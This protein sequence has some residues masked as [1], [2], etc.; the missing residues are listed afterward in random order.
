MK[1][2]V[3]SKKLKKRER[4]SS[5]C[6]FRF[7]KRGVQG[8]NSVAEGECFFKK[9]KKKGTPLFLQLVFLGFGKG[10]FRV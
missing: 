4:L 1:A 2:S 6:L 8:L 9:V 10:A 5:T 7:W 3:S